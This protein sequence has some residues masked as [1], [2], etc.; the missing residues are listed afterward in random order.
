MIAILSKF[1]R[2]QKLSEV[3]LSDLVSLFLDMQSL[4]ANR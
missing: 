2:S 3:K 1:D 4:K